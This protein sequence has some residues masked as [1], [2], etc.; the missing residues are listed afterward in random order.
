M[1]GSKEIREHMEVKAVDGRRIGTVDHMDGTLCIT[2]LK[3][4]AED[5]K[6]RLIPLE[7]VDRDAHLHLSKSVDEVRSQWVTIN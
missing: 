4:S 3:M 5:R 6:H 7:W 2:L 1:T